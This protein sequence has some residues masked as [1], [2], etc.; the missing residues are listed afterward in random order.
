MGLSRIKDEFKG[1]IIIKEDITEYV[2]S[3]GAEECESQFH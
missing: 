1:I 2:K 3:E